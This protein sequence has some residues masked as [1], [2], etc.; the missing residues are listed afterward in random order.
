MNVLHGYSSG[1][2]VAGDL[3]HDAFYRGVFSK[4]YMKAVFIEVFEYDFRV[5]FCHFHIFFNVEFHG[6]LDYSQAVVDTLWHFTKVILFSKVDVYVGFARTSVYICFHL[7]Y[8]T[9]RIYMFFNTELAAFIVASI[10]LSVCADE[11]KPVS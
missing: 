8:R 9:K 7:I 2:L 6:E 4:L 1:E 10:S 5:F 3:C 11:T